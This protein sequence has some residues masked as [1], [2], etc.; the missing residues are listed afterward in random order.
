[1]YAKITRRTRQQRIAYLTGTALAESIKGVLLQ[2][3]T[4]GDVVEIAVGKSLITFRR[5]VCTRDESSQLPWRR[6]GENITISHMN[7]PFIGL[8]DDTRYIQRRTTKVEETVGSA[9]L[10]GLQHRGKDVAEGLFCL[11]LRSHILAHSHHLRFGQCLGIDFAVRRNRHLGQL[12]IGRRNHI[13]GQALT[14]FRLYL[15]NWNLTV[16]HEVGTEMILAFQFADEYDDVVDALDLHHHAFNLAQFDTLTTQLHLIV[17]TSEDMYAPLLVPTG[18]VARTIEALPLPCDKGGSCLVWQVVITVS[19]LHTTNQQFSDHAYRQFVEILI[20]DALLH[21]Q[22]RT[23]HRDTFL[24]RQ[25]VAVALY[26]RLSRSVAVEDV[27]IWCL[28]LQTTHQT[29]REFLTTTHHNHTTAHGFHETVTGH[30]RHQA[31][32]CRA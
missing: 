8:D 15:F 25:F 19:H 4:N 29:I 3:G 16:G 27:S 1:M 30:E 26:G 7:A 14:D 6:V 20:D 28:L 9:H 24:V 31:R 32:L 21:V 17:G 5:P 13:G 18:E 2:E 11:V 23:A 22:Q 10:L 12:Q